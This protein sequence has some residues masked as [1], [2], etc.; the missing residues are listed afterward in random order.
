MN[1]A[2]IEFCTVDILLQGGEVCA[3][4]NT[5]AYSTAEV[6]IGVDGSLVTNNQFVW[7]D[8]PVIAACFNG[9]CVGDTP[10][11]DCLADPDNL[12]SSV[13]VTCGGQVAFASVSEDCPQQ[14]NPP[15]T[16]F[17]ADG[18]GGGRRRLVEHGTGWFDVIVTLSSTRIKSMT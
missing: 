12:I 4:G 6:D 7:S 1:A 14:D 5:D 8:R 18:E 11:E 13:R 2:A 3:S 9:N 10:I 15:S 16:I 17:A